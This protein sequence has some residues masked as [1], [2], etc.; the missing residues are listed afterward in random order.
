MIY[1]Y[2]VIGSGSSGGIIASRISENSE[3]SVL[4]L[5]AGKDYQNIKDLPSNI[6]KGFALNLPDGLS[7]EIEDWSY[8]GFRNNNNTI[9]IPRGKII[10]GSSSI[11]GQIFLRGIP[12][13]YDNWAKEGNN[14]WS[15]KNILPS[16][17]RIEN[18]LD[19][20][21]DFHGN[22][23]KIPVKRFPKEKWSP[24]DHALYQS[25]IDMGFPN[26]PDQNSPDATGVG[27]VPINNNGLSLPDFK[28]GLRI[29]SNI[30]YISETRERLNLTI[31]GNSF[32]K[33]ILFNRSNKKTTPKAYGVEVESGG[34]TY[35]IEGENIIL[36][37]GAIGSPHLLLLSGIGPK[38]DL[39]QFDIEVFNDLPGVGKNLRDHPTV[40]PRYKLIDNFPEEWFGV[41][42]RI[43]LRYTATGS[44]LKNDMIIYANS[45]LSPPTAGNQ[46]HYYGN[47]HNSDKFKNYPKEEMYLI[48]RARINLAI[49]SGEIKLNSSDPKKYPYINYNFLQEKFDRKRLR[50]ALKIALKLAD[51]PNFEKWISEKVT[52]TEKNL[53]NENS[54][55]EWMIENVC[56]GHHISGTC[57]MG[58]STDKMAVVNQYGKV[59]G[60]DGLTVA[61]ASKMVNCIRANTN[62]TSL[63][64]GERIS[65][66]ILNG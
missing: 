39:E 14:L 38:E 22:T 48:W 25:A 40:L 8:K 66:F 24:T 15:Y 42:D 29:S 59:H 28:E 34:N 54:I 57:K 7:E 6:R 16:L 46:A 58:P 65:E 10:G 45:V 31:K 3:N 47:F 50:E 32:V 27:P 61:D 43:C 63:M 51:H 30:A 4:L 56:H 9:D 26:C 60:I 41:P 12:E 18:D 44:H 62:V 17:N 20:S 19:F 5:E 23:G 35:F 53:Q 55:E 21:G 33:K 64:I 49:G 2:I 37:A 13:D 1:N 52:P 11:N 36:S